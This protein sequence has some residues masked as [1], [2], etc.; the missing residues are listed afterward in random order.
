MYSVRLMVCSLVLAISLAV[1]LFASSRV[2]ALESIMYDELTCE[3]LTHAYHFNKTVLEGM[4]T[5]YD[6]CLDYIDADLDGHPHGALTC[7]FIREHGL[8]VQGIVNDIAAV[9]NI[10]C[11][12]K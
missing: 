4:M 10:R 1:L 7:S 11:A 9:A 12:A 8:F 6:G 3:Q 5:Y 2:N